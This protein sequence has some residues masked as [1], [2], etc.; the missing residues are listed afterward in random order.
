M[1]PK[2]VKDDSFAEYNEEPNE[3]DPKFKIGDQVR[4]SKYFLYFVKVF[5][6]LVFFLK[7]IHL[8]G[9]EKSLLLKK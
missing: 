7:D 5:Q 1:K 8:I 9:V 2:D 4:I 3:K 6:V